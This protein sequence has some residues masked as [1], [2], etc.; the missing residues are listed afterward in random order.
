MNQCKPVVGSQVAILYT[1]LYLVALGTS[2]IKAVLPALGADQFD[3]KDPKEASQLSSFFNWFLF[4]LTT[5]AIVG[6]TVIVWISTN[7]GW[8]W[9][10]IVCTIAVLFSILFICMGKSLY[11]NNTPKGSP[12]IRIIQVNKVTII[13]FYFFYMIQNVIV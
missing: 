6:V 5:G 13:V 7:Q 11:R 8:Y 2:G 4:S 12:L 10:F 9:S 3:D 1:G